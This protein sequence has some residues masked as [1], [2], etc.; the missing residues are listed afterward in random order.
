MTLRHV[1]TLA[2][3]MLSVSSAS[4]STQAAHSR[5]SKQ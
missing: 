2:I 1:L 5:R 4:R 3:L